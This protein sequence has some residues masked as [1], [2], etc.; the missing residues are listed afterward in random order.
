MQM[1]IMLAI[2]LYCVWLAEVWQDSFLFWGAAMHRTALVAALVS[3]P[4]QLH[5][6]VLSTDIG[7][8]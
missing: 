1:S 5:Y 3:R 8:L 7:M 6:C 4:S 2:S